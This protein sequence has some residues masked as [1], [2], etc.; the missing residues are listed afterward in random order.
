MRRSSYLKIV[1]VCLLL[2]SAAVFGERQAP[3]AKANSEPRAGRVR[4][5]HDTPSNA[6]YT[7]GMDASGNASFTIKSGDFLLEKALDANGTFTLRLTQNKDVV[8]IVAD[9]SGYL[10]SHGNRSARLDPRNPTQDARLA[11][12]SVLLG[13]QAVRSFRRLAVV[14][15]N[16]SEQDDD[17]PPILS[18]LID[19]S[20]VQVLDGDPGAGL[21]IAKRVARRELAKIKPAR[22]L[23]GGF[24]DC[25]TMYELSLLDAYSQ[26]E[27]CLQ[28]AVKVHWWFEDWAEEFCVSE[29]LLRSQ[30]YVWQFTVCML[31]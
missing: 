4:E 16:R 9:Q 13:S 11:V 15:E 22:L 18:A 12:R 6:D 24:N 1:A 8:V 31:P 27:Q 20:V 19:S 7:V 25:V 26:L 30:Q 10:V 23:P 17:T 5:F 14:L 29:W 3:P 2:G 21:R 28:W